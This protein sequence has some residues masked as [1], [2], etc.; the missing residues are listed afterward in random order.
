MT[1]L[2]CM[3]VLKIMYSQFFDPRTSLFHGLNTYYYFEKK[4]LHLIGVTTPSFVTDTH[5]LKNV[6][7]YPR[8]LF[9]VQKKSF[10]YF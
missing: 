6:K 4:K 2:R 8:D 3:L 7:N 1:V 10:P 9:L 5:L